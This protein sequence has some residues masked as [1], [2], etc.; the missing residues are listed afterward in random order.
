MLGTVGEISPEERKEERFRGVKS[1]TIIGKGG[2]ERAYDRSLRGI[3]GKQ[4]IQVDAFGR[5]VPNPRL[6]RTKP[7]AG[8]RL[9]LSL[10]LGL[11]RATQEALREH[12]RRA[13]RAPRSPWTRATGRSWRW[14][15]TRRS[16]RRS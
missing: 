9:R 10:D 15:R 8:Q 6:K 5:P 12:R 11:E 2:L 13:T 14:R 16:T 3:D 1:G 4:R 7:I